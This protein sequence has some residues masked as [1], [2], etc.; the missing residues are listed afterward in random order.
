MPIKQALKDLA[1]IRGRGRRY[2]TYCT[3]K[4]LKKILNRLIEDFDAYRINSITGF[5]CG[6]TIE[7]AY[8]VSVKDK[9]ITIKV[10]VPKAKPEIETITNMFPSAILF[11]R[12][13]ME[14]FGVKVLN[15]PTGG[16]LFLPDDFPDEH[17]L[18]KDFKSKSKK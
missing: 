13:L 9:L 8:N 15:H 2:Y 16:R 4:S 6:N 1:V 14:M 5:D 3:R 7:V 10:P 17:P 11:E 18:L 12:E